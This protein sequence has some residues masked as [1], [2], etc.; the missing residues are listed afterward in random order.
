MAEVEIEIPIE[1]EVLASMESICKELGITVND[2]LT[3]CA[4]EFVAHRGFPFEVTEEELEAARQS[5]ENHG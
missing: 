2:A 3:V 5:E 4:R 1:D